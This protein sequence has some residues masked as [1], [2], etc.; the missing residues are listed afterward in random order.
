MIDGK[1]IDLKI[2]NQI[3]IH[4]ITECKCLYL[5]NLKWIIM[6]C[7]L[8][9]ISKPDGYYGVFFL[10]SSNVFVKSYS[11]KKSVL[12]ILAG[13]KSLLTLVNK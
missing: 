4:F 6:F 13:K 11:T 12:F 7:V 1:K 3:L 8:T 9:N 10:I 2:L 5:S